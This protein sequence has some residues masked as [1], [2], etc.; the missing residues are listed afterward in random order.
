VFIILQKKNLERKYAN[1]FLTPLGVS[2]KDIIVDTG[3][4]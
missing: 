3:F 1:I 2:K 4:W